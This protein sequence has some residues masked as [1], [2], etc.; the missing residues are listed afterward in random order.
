MNNLE[1]LTLII[2]GVFVCAANWRAGFIVTMIAGFLAD[3]FRKIVPN[4][5]VYLSAAVG[6]FVAATC[7]GAYMRGVRLSFRPI[8]SWN[9]SLRTPTG[10]FVALVVL[11]SL[12]AFAR[13]GSP[14]VAVIGLL[15]YLSPLPAILLGYN[16]TRTERDPILYMKLYLVL[17]LVMS[18][19]IFLSYS[20]YESP[21][22]ESVGTP[23]ITFA[24]TGEQLTL[25][26]G[27]FRTVEVAAWHLGAAVCILGILL[28]VI[29]KKLLKWICG[30]LV[31]VFCVALLLTGRRK[32]IVEIAIFA[33]I[34]VLLLTL[35]RKGALKSAAAAMVAVVMGFAVYSYVVPDDVTSTIRPYYDRSENVEAQGIDRLSGNTI[36][37]FQWVIAQNGIFGSGAGTGSQGAQY[38]GGGSALVGS[39]AEG[40]LGKV[41]AELGVP[42]LLLVLWIAVATA[43]YL[44]SVIKF[45]KSAGED[46]ARLAFGLVAFLAANAFV[47]IVA[48][49]A[50]GDV[51]VLV[52]LG[53]VLG[54]AMAMPRIQATQSAQPSG[55]TLHRQAYPVTA[56]PASRR[57]I[58]VSARPL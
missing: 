34:Y 49:Q 46:R 40:G 52:N 22:L 3:P 23:L 18:S 57:T 12:L 41:L 35:F 13:T 26:P 50:F 20:G 58:T 21:L 53:F 5:P 45:L 31:A 24:P 4:E 14:M 36:E 44:W 42:G 39:A 19:G 8:H 1:V 32:F 27:F 28:F 43:Q 56:V 9:K 17:V 2:L 29:K 55:P 6:V 15:A 10:L 33:V 54:F 30:P 48:H 51:F 37:S 25:F 38:F 16:F 11:Q 7:I 47:Y